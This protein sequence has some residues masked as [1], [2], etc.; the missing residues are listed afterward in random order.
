MLFVGVFMSR[1][2][3]C[4]W[5]LC[6]RQMQ[7]NVGQ[8][9]QHPASVQP[10]GEEDRRAERAPLGMRGRPGPARWSRRLSPGEALRRGP[11]SRRDA[12]RGPSLG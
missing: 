4:C 12:R 10:E 8:M 2:F 9:P 5:H 3:C 7:E 11:G 6:A 1:I